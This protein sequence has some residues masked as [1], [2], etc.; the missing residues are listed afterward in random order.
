[1]AKQ[2]RPLGDRIVVKPIEEEEMTPGGI[3]VP[4][5]AKERPQEG[6]VI[7]VGSGEIRDDGT[8]V[9]LDLSVGDRVIFA[10]YAGTEFKLD[11]EKFLILSERDVLAVV[12]DAEE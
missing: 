10:K 7:A 5:T 11:G 8:R 1:M 4:E 6:R 12:E 3:Y 9:P 2:L